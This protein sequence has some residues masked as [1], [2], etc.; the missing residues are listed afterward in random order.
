MVDVDDE[1]TVELDPFPLFSCGHQERTAYSPEEAK[2]TLCYNCIVGLESEE[3]RQYTKAIRDSG[4]DI[5]AEYR[6]AI[7]PANDFV[8]DAAGN[9]HDFINAGVIETTQRKDN[10]DGTFSL[11]RP[12]H[13]E[14]KTGETMTDT[15]TQTLPDI[16]K[17]V[18]ERVS[19]IDD[20][21]QRAA[22][23]RARNEITS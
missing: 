21:K 19:D 9:R 7:L 4:R 3:N 15:N 5:A 16:F 23:L 13:L 6:K 17:E 10:G 20:P 18:A 14:S 1:P 8:I 11:N 12:L 2:L 22:A